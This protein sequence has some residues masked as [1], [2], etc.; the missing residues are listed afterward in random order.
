MVR[1]ITCSVWALGFSGMDH[2]KHVVGGPFTWQD[3]SME[4]T[5]GF[6]LPCKYFSG[7]EG[8]APSSLLWRFLLGHVRLLKSSSHSPYILKNFF[9]VCV[10]WTNSIFFLATPL[11]VLNPSLSIWLEL[12]A[13]LPSQGTLECQK[14]RAGFSVGYTWIMQVVSHYC[15][16]MWRSGCFAI[17]VRF[18]T[19]KW[20]HLIRVPVFPKSRFFHFNNLRTGTAKT[21]ALT[22][23][24]YQK[25]IMYQIFYWILYLIFSINSFSMKESLYERGTLIVPIL[26]TKNLGRLLTVKSIVKQKPL[27][28]YSHGA[29]A[30]LNN[31][32]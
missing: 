5:K 28:C 25:F 14:T 11:P 3:L 20:N 19:S 22:A 8:V 26:W 12:S 16:V 31:L 4:W 18:P 24:I 13:V 27:F 2:I 21:T 6:H 10:F 32:M 9:C 23:N 30:F 15:R 29:L 1:E 17:R 7:S